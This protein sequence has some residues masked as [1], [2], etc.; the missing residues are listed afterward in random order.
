LKLRNSDRKKIEK[1][2]RRLMNLKGKGNSRKKR[3][4]DRKT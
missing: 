2:K 4:R 3:S 1:R